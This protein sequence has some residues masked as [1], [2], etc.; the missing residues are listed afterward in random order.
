MAGH[1]QGDHP[2]TAATQEFHDELE[3]AILGGRVPA[4]FEATVRSLM[5]KP[6]LEARGRETGMMFEQ[7]GPANAYLAE[8]ARRDFRGI[9]YDRDQQALLAGTNMA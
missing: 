3:A 4:Y 5:A 9:P 6:T 1:A 8:L 7:L 2:A